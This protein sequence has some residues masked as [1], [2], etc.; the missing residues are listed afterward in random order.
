MKI[1][2]VNRV[3]TI[4]FGTHEPVTALRDWDIETDDRRDE[5]SAEEIALALLEHYADLLRKHIGA[6]H[7]HGT[8]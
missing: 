8:A 1:T 4:E 3:G 5:M 7:L 6:K 2:A